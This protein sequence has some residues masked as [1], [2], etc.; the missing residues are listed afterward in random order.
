MPQGFS[1]TDQQRAKIIEILQKRGAVRACSRCGTDNFS[2]NDGF[3][4]DLVGDGKNFVLGGPAIP[5]IVII[6]TN[7]GAIYQHALGV[8]GLFGEFGFPVP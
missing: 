6:C 5:S 2:L 4:M 7:C 8:L 3:F 1:F